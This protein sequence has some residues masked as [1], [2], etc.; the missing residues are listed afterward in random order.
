[1]IR[2]TAEDV[3]RLC[4]LSARTIR[5]YV[6]EKL[7]SPPRGRGRGAHFDDGHLA[8]LRAVRFM[9]NA[10]LDHVGIR[11]AL[12]EQREIMR[13]RGVDPASA[14]RLLSSYAGQALE[15]WMPPGAAP[16]PPAP[17]PVAER[18]TRLTLAPGLTLTV[19]DAW[20]LPSASKL[21]EL[22]AAVSRAFRP[23]SGA[24]DGERDS[25]AR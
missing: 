7:I 12:A 3:A 9:Q 18:L 4:G 14:Q 24:R 21:A 19:S 23:A 25:G 17:P 20:R 2:Y 5:Y 1:M 6:A 8:E 16:G 22:A 10:G 15:V 11:S 13:E